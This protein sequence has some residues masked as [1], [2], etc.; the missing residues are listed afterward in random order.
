MRWQFDSSKA[1]AGRDLCECPH[2]KV[3]PSQPQ[4]QQG[5]KGRKAALAN[6]VRELK[7]VAEEVRREPSKDERN[8]LR[9]LPRPKGVKAV[10]TQRGARGPETPKWGAL[11]SELGGP[12]RD[13]GTVVTGKKQ[14]G[15]S[16]MAT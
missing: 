10:G 9:E 4:E 16:V 14:S 6:Q 5:L 1:R 3:G 13:P 11:C 8:G 2:E 7:R 12:P 15:P